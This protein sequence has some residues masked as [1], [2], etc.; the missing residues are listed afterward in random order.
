MR[1]IFCKDLMQENEELKKKLETLE[2]EKQELA[3]RYEDS[4]SK[5]KNLEQELRTLREE[6]QEIAKKYEDSTSKLKNLEQELSTLREE[7]Q[8]LVKRYEDSTSKVKSLEHELS[9]LREEKQNFIAK[10]EVLEK[11]KDNLSLKLENLQ[12]DLETFKAKA[13]LGFDLL[14]ALQSEGVFV[15]TPEFKP[16]KEGNALVYINKR[17]IEILKKNG[18]IINKT[19]GYNIDWSNPLGISIHKFHK[20]PERIKELF[21]A[22]KPGEVLKN[23]DIPMGSTIIE[24]YRTAIYD[25]KGNVIN[26]ASVWKDATYER[27]VDT[28]FYSTIPTVVKLY[29]TLSLLETYRYR[30]DIQV[31]NFKEE[32]EMIIN[33]ITEVNQGI[34]E[35]SRAIHDIKMVGQQVANYVEEGLG[36]LNET[37][38]N[39]DASIR[40]IDEVSKNSDK[41]RKSINS[42]N[43][44]VEVIM[45]IT[46]QT[47]LLS[48]NAAIEAARAGEVGRGFAVVAD[49]VRKLAEK[50]S[51]SAVNIRELIENIIEEAKESISKTENAKKTITDNSEY[52]KQLKDSFYSIK[53]SFDELSSLIEKQSVATEEQSTVM[54]SITTSVAA[55]G[56]GIS[57]IE[58]TIEK[59][60][61]VISEAVNLSDTTFQSLKAIKPGMY[62]EIYQR[63]VDHAKFILN[64][65]NMVEDKISWSV[66]DYTQCAFGKWYYSPESRTFVS[67]CSTNA[68]MAF[69]EVENPHKHY[70]QIAMEI[71]RL[72]RQGKKDE[73]YNKFVEIIDYS[74]A[75][76]DKIASLAESLKEC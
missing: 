41:L 63:A 60:V 43:Q 46:E 53:H 68:L 49:E 23:T 73:L 5:V 3:K 38:K 12:K 28:M 36:K 59:S 16:G 31:G 72:K 40:A 24:S 11:E 52:L 62:T 25:D 57:K 30:V 34:A 56:D 55:L 13:K 6:K 76:V 51:K 54:N 58:E 65:M 14:E 10:F 33:S 67:R 4:T 64:V 22:L 70:H 44:I 19:F 9:T 21:K 48:L 50:T 20:D 18:D 32:L 74:T 8:E 42:I 45:D 27:A 71:E 1:G 15:V 26:Y 29:H 17:G 2:R 37:A 35:L 66:P 61:P 39:I 69:E 75:I 7:K 47:N